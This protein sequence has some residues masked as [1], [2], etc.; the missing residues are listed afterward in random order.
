VPQSSI[1]EYAFIAW[2]GLYTG[3]TYLGFYTYC[4]GL[5]GSYRIRGLRGPA[6]MVKSKQ[7]VGK[8][9]ITVCK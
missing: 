4:V 3:L 5:I 6:A 2:T 7:N 8:Q 1:Q 9:S